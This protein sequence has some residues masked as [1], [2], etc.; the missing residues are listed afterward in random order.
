MKLS[1]DSLVSN[2]WFC[3]FRKE[4]E[5]LFIPFNYNALK[6]SIYLKAN[7]THEINFSANEASSSENDTQTNSIKL[8]SC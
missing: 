8:L 2:A 7:I 1:I 4:K 3:L 6:S 5:E